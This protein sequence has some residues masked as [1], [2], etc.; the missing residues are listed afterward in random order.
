MSTSVT[1]LETLLGI[2][3]RKDCSGLRGEVPLPQSFGR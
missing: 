2:V 1:P 3:A